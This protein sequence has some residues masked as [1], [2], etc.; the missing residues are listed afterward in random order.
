[1]T[2]RRGSKGGRAVEWPGRGGGTVGVPLAVQLE[3]MGEEVRL[4]LKVGS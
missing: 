1:M 4:Q 2:R 3:V